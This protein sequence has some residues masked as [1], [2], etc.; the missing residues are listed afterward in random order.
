MNHIDDNKENNSIQ[1]LYAGTQ[2]RNIEDCEKNGHRVGNVKAITLLDKKHN[3]I[4]TFPS[5]KHFIEYDG[6]SNRS[7]SFSKAKNKIWF[8]ERYEIISIESVTTKERYTELK[9]QFKLDEN[10]A[11]K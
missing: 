11:E 5:V 8:K 7:G 4:I 10:K 2:K 1:N 6:H 3:K 9:Q